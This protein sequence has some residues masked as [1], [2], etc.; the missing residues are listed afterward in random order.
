MKILTSITFLFA[1]LF[2]A[3]QDCQLVSLQL[4]VPA[5]AS[6]HHFPMQA[7]PY[8]PNC[9]LGSFLTTWQDSE[10]VARIRFSNDGETWTKWEVIK[11][12]YTKPED[13]FSSLHHLT[14]EYAYFEWA[15]Y[16]KGGQATEFS[17]NFY[18][19]TEEVLFADIA[20]TE[21]EVSEAVCPEPAVEQEEE[22]VV[23]T[24]PDDE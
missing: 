11:R 14:Q 2:L 13:T 12:D 10:I 16:N 4:D 17:L 24:A 8:N 20:T 3:A 7:M 19:P 9:D 22:V 23:T 6:K 21:F 5:G 15:I 18:Y 1:T